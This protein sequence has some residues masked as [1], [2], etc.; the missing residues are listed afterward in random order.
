MTA[1]GA[2][3]ERPAA[4]SLAEASDTRTPNGLNGLCVIRVTAGGLPAK[5]GCNT[6]N[7]CNAHGCPGWCED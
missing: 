1:L 7:S 2:V 3:A 4:A 6:E 5:P